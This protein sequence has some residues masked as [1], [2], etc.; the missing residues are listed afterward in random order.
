MV[1]TFDSVRVH[2]KMSVANDR[3]KE[4]AKA[5]GVT[6]VV[7]A[8]GSC[9]NLLP[10]TNATPKALIKVGHRSLIC[11]TIDNLVAA[12]I[13]TIHIIVSVDD[14]KCIEDHVRSEFAAEGTYG[15]RNGGNDKLDI[16]LHPIVDRDELISTT[17]DVLRYAS[18]LM[19]TDF[20]VV[21]CDL[22]GTLNIRGLVESHLSTKRLC[23][24]ALLEEKSNPQETKK[25]KQ[26][27]DDQIAPGG[28]PVKGWGYKY[29]VMATMD[30]DNSQLLGI[31]DLLTINSGETYA[32]DKWTARRHPRCVIRN[33]LY[34]AHIYVFSKHIRAIAELPCMEH[35]SI[36]LD[37]IPHIVKMQEVPD[38]ATWPSRETTS[39]GT[40]EERVYVKDIEQNDASDA[41]R[42]F[43]YMDIGD[44]TKCG[45]VN[46]L[47]ALMNVNMQKAVEGA[48]KQAGQ[49]AQAAGVKM[50]DVIIATG[51][52]IGEG[53]NARGCVMG[54][55][56]TIG[57]NCKLS[58]CVI[59]NDVT[60]QDNVNLD[61]CII[62]QGATVSTKATLKHVV[63]APDH[64][65]PNNTRVERD[66]LPSF[67]D[68]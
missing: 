9:D 6:A 30:A 17:T 38:A 39:N 53:T 3:V 48:Q 58:K 63:V 42:V 10:L 5:L 56:V 36:R 1:D 55:N 20:M 4:D 26:T 18:E 50:R 35:T 59:M 61:R 13:Y 34:D 8:A 27:P 16:S 31:A 28:D 14:Q 32:V 11:G 52:N 23:T 7:L 51:C 54:E 29:R 33:D 44:S 64:T 15:T 2:L 24:V 46:S 41:M 60:L 22:F 57:K 45:R 40:Q 49:A 62:G 67:I 47:E 25:T 21:P 43:H 37:L 65:V 12:G 68:Q 66:F 19:E